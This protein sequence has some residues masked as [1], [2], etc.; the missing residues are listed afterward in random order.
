MWPRKHSRPA[1]ASEVAQVALFSASSCESRDLASG[2]PR[3]VLPLVLAPG[4][5]ACSYGGRCRPALPLA[6]PTRP[7]VATGRSSWS[8]GNYPRL[9]S[10]KLFSITAIV[11][12]DDQH[13]AE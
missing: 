11:E 3:W 9:M 2:L 1:A 5:F 8:L 13:D 7:V 6:A 4:V 12:A 10:Q